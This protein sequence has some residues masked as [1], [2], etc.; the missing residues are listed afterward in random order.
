M[1]K[2]TTWSIAATLL[3]LIA[4]A[5]SAQPAP[6]FSGRWTT[7]PDPAAATP[8]AGTQAG[9][10]RGAGAPRGGGGGRGGRAGDMGSGWGST[11][12]VAQDAARLTVQYMFF[13]RG[14]MQPPLRFVYALDGSETKNTVM[15]GHGLQVQTSKAVW[16]AAKLVITT[17]H[18]FAN[19]ET[20]RP[21]TTTV[22]QTLS[23]ESPTSLVV[24]TTRGAVL[25]GPPSTVRTVYRKLQ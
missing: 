1:R 17:V 9:A 3:L 5:A 25:G 16:D 13:T 24:E 22:T 15:M 8:A 20:G 18:T 14:D 11:I 23:L 4:A 21:M 2:T 19:P 12:T 7:D 6:D 10:A